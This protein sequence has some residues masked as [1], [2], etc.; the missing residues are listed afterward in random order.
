LRRCCRTILSRHLS[1]H[2]KN[3]HSLWRAHFLLQPRSRPTLPGRPR[4]RK[5]TSRNTRFQNSMTH[6]PTDPVRTRST[7]SQNNDYP[8]PGD[9]HGTAGENVAF[10]GGQVEWVSQ[11][12]ELRSWFRGND[13]EHAPTK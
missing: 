7:S 10:T 8:D 5:S 3:S 1:T 4:S 6:L 13:E 2:H 12:K 9:N 11:K